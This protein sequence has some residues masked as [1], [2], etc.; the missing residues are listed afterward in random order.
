[1]YTG[2]QDPR[3]RDDWL[4]LLLSIDPLLDLA[5]PLVF[6]VEEIGFA[7]IHEI[8]HRLRRQELKLIQEFNLM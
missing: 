7:H 1:M 8:D 5:Q 6:L 4:I 2:F 3:V